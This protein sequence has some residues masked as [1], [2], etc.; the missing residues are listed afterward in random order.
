[1]RNRYCSFLSSRELET[2]LAADALSL[3][4]RWQIDNN[5]RLPNPETAL[6]MPVVTTDVS[7][8]LQGNPAQGFQ[9]GSGVLSTKFL[10]E[11]GS[12]QAGL[13]RVAQDLVST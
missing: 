12:D 8:V 4:E 2:S 5:S 10:K 1:M 6:L 11:G 7:L 9:E 3:S 13:P